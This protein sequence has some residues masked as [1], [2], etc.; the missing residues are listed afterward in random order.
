MPAGIQRSTY[1]APTI[2][3]AKL[4]SVRFSVENQAARPGEASQSY[5]WDVWMRRGRASDDRWRL[6]SVNATHGPRPRSATDPVVVAAGDVAEVGG[7]QRLT[8]DRVRLR[9]DLQTGKP[10]RN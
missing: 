1:S 10:V 9:L 8:S 5:G 3:S 2:A 7:H 6:W 4:F